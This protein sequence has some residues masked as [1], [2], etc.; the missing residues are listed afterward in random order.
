MNSTVS[1]MCTPKHLRLTDLV[2]FTVDLP[3]LLLVFSCT[4][5]FISVF[6]ILSC[7]CSRLKLPT[8]LRFAV[9]YV[10]TVV[11][12]L[13]SYPIDTIRRRMMMTSGGGTHYAGS[14]DCAKQIMKNEGVS[15]FFKGAGANILRGVAGAGVLAGFDTVVDAYVEFKFGPGCTTKK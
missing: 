12:G 8:L 15:S 1:L 13:A 4:V 10:V 14:L 7:P 11:A 3:F 2:D 5:D 6:T 9:G